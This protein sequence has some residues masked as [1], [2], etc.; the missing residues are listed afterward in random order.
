MLKEARKG[1][2]QLICMSKQF[3]INFFCCKSLKQIVGYLTTGLL[4]FQLRQ[5]LTSCALP[6]QPCLSKDLPLK[7]H[8]FK[9]IFKTNSVTYIFYKRF[10]MFAILFTFCENFRKFC[11]VETEIIRKI[12]S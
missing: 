7:S 12:A 6:W 8:F 4:K 5:L 9:F 1:F 10:S 11:S 3:K 2:L